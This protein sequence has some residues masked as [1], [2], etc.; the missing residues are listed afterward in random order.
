M[1]TPDIIPTAEAA[2]LVGVSVATINRWADKGKLPTIAQA[3][4]PTGA[5]FFLRSDVA[6]VAEKRRRALAAKL[7]ALPTSEPVA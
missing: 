7:A 4:G 1:P 2:A 6:T 3:S 5:R